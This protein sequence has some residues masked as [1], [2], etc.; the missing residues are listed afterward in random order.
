MKNTKTNENSFSICSSQSKNLSSSNSETV[1]SASYLAIY[2]R[3]KT[4]EQANLYA[5]QAQKRSHHK[6]RPLEKSFELEKQRIVDEVME[7]ENKAAIVN[8]KT[9]ING[10]LLT[11]TSN[12]PFKMSKD[13]SNNYHLHDKISVT[14]NQLNNNNTKKHNLNK[15]YHINNLTD[16]INQNKN[17]TEINSAS[18]D[19]IYF[20]PESNPHHRYSLLQNNEP[21]DKFIDELIEEKKTKILSSP[22]CILQ[23]NKNMNHATY[24]LLTYITLMEMR[25]NSHN[26]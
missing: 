18:P 14:Q 4:A 22:F 17:L 2:E 24:H 7:A 12:A 13:C 6:L 21:I 15:T 8:F 10:V 11:Q 9:H 1:S 25:V 19:K 23:F 26:L 20:L 16:Y 3:R 5:K